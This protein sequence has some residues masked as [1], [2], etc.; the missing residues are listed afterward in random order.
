MN[1]VEWIMPLLQHVFVEIVAMGQPLIFLC[2]EENEYDDCE[3]IY[4]NTYR[5]TEQ[6]D[7]A[8]TG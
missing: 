6:F 7:F 4:R 8:I 1:G 3:Q 2:H 5:Q